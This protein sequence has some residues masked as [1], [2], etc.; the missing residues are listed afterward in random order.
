MVERCHGLGF[1][2]EAFAERLGGHLDRDVSVEAGIA[3]PI[4]FGHPAGADRR[5]DFVWAEARSGR[6]SHESGQF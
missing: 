6:Q 3:R 1:G 2:A 5:N 4:N